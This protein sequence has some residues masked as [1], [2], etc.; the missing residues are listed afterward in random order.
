MRRI[1]VTFSLLAG[2]VEAPEPQVGTVSGVSISN[3][4]TTHQGTTHQGST[5]QGTSYDGTNYQG[6]SYQGASYGGAAFTTRITEKSSL[7]LSRWFPTRRVWEVRTPNTLCYHPEDPADLDLEEGTTVS[8]HSSS[9]SPLAGARF[10]ARFHD[11]VTNTMRT[12]VL[13]IGASTTTQV[14]C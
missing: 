11:P 8:V 14:L 1:L 7:E 9:V 3:Q 4:G 12:G 2:C 13:R 6:T 10:N 5:H